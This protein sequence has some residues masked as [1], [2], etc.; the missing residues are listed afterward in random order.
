MLQNRAISVPKPLE[1]RRHRRA[2]VSIPGRYMLENR[3]EFDCRL[4]DISVGG[5]AVA[6]PSKGAVGE[7]VV[8]YFEDIGRL[9]GMVV[10]S[11][12]DG[13]AVVMA[14]A[15]NK[16]ER[17]ADLLTWLVNRENVGAVSDRK[18][19][20]ITPRNRIADMTIV[21][22]GRRHEVEVIDVSQSGVGVK[23]TVA[24]EIDTRVEIG[25]R[26]GRIVRHFPDGLAVVFNRLIPI[27]EFDEDIIL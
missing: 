12:D 18:H 24:P 5:L 6:A 15:P 7:K 13:F 19:K 14:L 22:T 3:R 4:M 1:L 11:F 17:L 23:T 10:R 9:E 8:F 25:K 20:R 16:R 21:A 27:E 26:S 2:A